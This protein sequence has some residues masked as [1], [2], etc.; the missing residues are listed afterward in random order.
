MFKGKHYSLMLG[1]ALLINL[2]LSAQED[3]TPPDQYG[4]LA[5]HIILLQEPFFWL[6][7]N[8]IYTEMSR[9]TLTLNNE[10][11]AYLIRTGEKKGIVIMLHGIMGRKEVFMPLVSYWVGMKKP[12]PTL[13]AV[14]LLGHGSL[15]YPDDYDFS[16]QRFTEYT[17]RFVRHIQQQ[18]PTEPIIILGHSLGGAVASLLLPL[19]SIFASATILISPAGAKG[20]NVTDFKSRIDAQK[21][22]P[23]HFGSKDIC[24]L[25]KSATE[26]FSS[27]G[28]RLF[29]GS[30]S[31]YEYIACPY[32]SWVKN[33]MFANL[34][35]SEQQLLNA[36]P[37]EKMFRDYA[38]QPVIL[39]WMRSDNMFH[40]SR[41]LPFEEL[42]S[43]QSTCISQELEGSHFWPMEHPGQA[44]V[45]LDAIVE[46]YLPEVT[47]DKYPV[48]PVYPF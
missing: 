26:P 10:K 40:K 13:I 17:A 27:A 19:A 2:N 45:I 28:A 21:G 12:L 6:V 32:E 46:E 18:H 33:R 30:C 8:T 39:L 43:E 47:V 42:L 7:R 22:L 41:F 36:T 35:T 4:W 1:L 37:V 24:Q 20:T 34:T 3:D 15:D 31:I 48:H 14:D 23:F 29:D 25:I 9:K 11:Y 5:N 38:D 16:I 44:A